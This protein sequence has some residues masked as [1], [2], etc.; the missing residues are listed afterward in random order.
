MS[1]R[2]DQPRLLHRKSQFGYTDD[3][4][5]AVFAEPEAVSREDQELLTTRAHRA[6]QQAQVAEWMVHRAEIERRI[7]WLYSQRFQ[8]DVS[9]QLRQLTKQL[10]RLDQ[11]I[12]S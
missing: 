7:A 10:E 11:K 3:P 4:S 5:K 2:R 9:A 6:A 8:R 12:A 1:A